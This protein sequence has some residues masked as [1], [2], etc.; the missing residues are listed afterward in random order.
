MS[1]MFL[2]LDQAG[3]LYSQLY[4]A[5][6]RQILGGRMRPGA[7]LPSTRWLAT[8]LG[9]SRNTALL[10]YEQLIAEG[11]LTAES[12]AG[13][14]VAAELPENLTFV[15]ADRVSRKHVVP[16]AVHLSSF[17]ARVADDPVTASLIRQ[18]LL[19]PPL[20]YDFRYGRPSFADFP[21]ATWDRTLARRARSRSIGDLDYGAPEGVAPLREELA[22][23]L[24]R[25][26]A[27]N[28]SPE[29]II[30]VS[31]SQQAID[32]AVRVL[33]DRGDRVV[34]ENPHY[35]PA[36]N[37]SRAAGAT[38]EFVDVDDQ[39]M[40][41]SDLAAKRGA[42]KLVFVTPS[43][44]FPTGALM[45]LGRRL[46]LLAWANRTG[47]VIFEDDYDSEYRYSGR[48][49]EALQALDE[50]GRVLYSGTF[51]KT[52]FPG[53]RLG[54]LVVP[55]QLV[56]IFRSVKSL[57]DTA[58]PTNTQLAL[59]EFM[60]DGHF[61]RHLR[62]SRARNAARCA[63]L[64]ESIDR[65]LGTQVEVSGSEGGLHILL[66][67]NNL[68]MRRGTDMVE[69]AEQAGVG[70][71]PVGPFYSRPPKRTGLLLGYTSLTEKE[72]AEGIRRL[73]SAVVSMSD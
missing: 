56:E 1:G 17:A 9:I 43:H 7:R 47:A 10:A 3:P 49:V 63:V 21:H 42:L 72:I 58:C 40:K 4:R 26:R 6:R 44:Q 53:L 59:A 23:Y 13:T 70:V 71:Y 73:A 39:G 12:H 34:L 18:I 27:V 8:E 38:I 36:R 60:R 61:E 25:A 14:Y 11:Y 19:R 28:C 32:L 51:S 66:W 24:H 68:S 41:I 37:V 69:R 54:Y 31:G 67:L 5:L 45:P 65:Y 52:M 46:E 48:P 55:N 62:R 16:S 22:D 20:P 35:F 30:I 2:K 33:V 57:L 29:Q 15:A 64:L 50:S